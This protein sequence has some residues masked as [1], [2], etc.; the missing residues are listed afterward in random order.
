M[1]YKL[2]LFPTPQVTISINPKMSMVFLNTYPHSNR[3]RLR[4]TVHILIDPIFQLKDMLSQGMLFP[5]PGV[6]PA[7][8]QGLMRGHTL[9]LRPF[10]L[11]KV[12]YIH[13]LSVLVPH[14][15][16]HALWERSCRTEEKGRHGG[17]GW[18]SSNLDY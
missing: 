5:R 12:S 6:C 7:A 14:L 15:L 1:I 16:S 13:T 10:T 9:G 4:I 18:K 11:N 2:I 8:D 17:H 3:L